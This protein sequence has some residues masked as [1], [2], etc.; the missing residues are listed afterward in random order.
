M[1]NYIYVINIDEPTELISKSKKKAINYF[2]E[3]ED[4]TIDIFTESWERMGDYENSGFDEFG[5]IENWIES[6]ILDYHYFKWLNN[7]HNWF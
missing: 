1:S 6:A 3:F 7:L 4:S 5:D 2:L